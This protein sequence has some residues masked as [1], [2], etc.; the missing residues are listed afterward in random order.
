MYVQ[1]ETYILTAK[2]VMGPLGLVK[3]QRFLLFGS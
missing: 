2:T 3:S 1:L